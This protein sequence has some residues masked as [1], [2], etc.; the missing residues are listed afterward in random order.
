M[1]E[2]R[3]RGYTKDEVIGIPAASEAGTIGPSGSDYVRALLDQFPGLLWTTDA[4]LRIT[5]CLGRAWRSMGIG[6]NQLAGA[7]VFRLFEPDG[8][9]ALDAHARALGGDTVSFNLR[10][11]SRTMH[12]TVAPLLDSAGRIFGVIGQAVEASRT[13]RRPGALLAT[14]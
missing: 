4:E 10:L 14:G 7:E 3:L 1:K 2:W 9:P 12:A 11:A 8:A 6:P 5:S 13:P